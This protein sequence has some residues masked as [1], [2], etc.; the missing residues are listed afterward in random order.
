MIPATTVDVLKEIAMKTHPQWK[1]TFTTVLISTTVLVTL[2]TLTALAQV[3]V[4]RHASPKSG[5][6]NISATTSNTPLFLPVV[7][8]GSG[9]TGASSVAVADVNGDG[10][11]DLVVANICA[12][13]TDCSTGTVAVLLGNG[14]GTFQTAVTYGSGGQGATSVA[15]GDLNGDGKP[16][17]AVVNGSSPKVGVLLGN[18]D[19]TF[20]P[21]QTYPS[22]GFGTSSVAIADVNG[23]GKLD[24]LIVNLEEEGVAGVLL[25]NGDGTFEPVRTISLQRYY[26]RSI[27]VADVNGDG[28]P[29]LV[30]SFFDSCPILSGCVTGGVGVLLGNGD[31]TFQ[32]VQIYN[33]E[34]YGASAVAVADLNGN[35]RADVVVGGSCLTFS[36][37]LNGDL[38]VLLGNGDHTFQPAVGYGSG[39]YNV[40]SVAVADVNGDGKPDLLVANECPFSDCF[41]EAVVGVL[42]GNGDGTFQKAVTF[43][44]GGYLAYGVAVGDVNGDGR[45]DVV[46]ANLCSD[47]FSCNSEDGTVGGLGSVGVLLNN[48]QGKSTTSTSL[49]SSL[50]PSTYGQKITWTATVTSSGSVTPTGKVKFTWNGYTIGAATLN[51][52]GVA[53]LTK[54]NLN[55]DAYPLTAVYAGDAANL[56]STSAVLNQVV[57]ETT[58]TATLTSSPNPSTQGQAVTFTVKISSPTVTPTGP[59]TFT[60]G[61]TVLGTAQLSGGKATLTTSALFV[62]STKVT[63]TYYGD[64]NIAKSSASVTQTVQ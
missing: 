2:S 43:S 23:D 55:A 30:V 29:D 41:N 26:P 47:P 14:D 59:V 17:L 24:L 27:A 57:F 39:A 28:K 5:T 51:S 16:D 45:P 48:A 33:S 15:V 52:S 9:G 31:G 8:Y 36:A 64:S 42:Q 54:S 20:Q 10:K 18:G 21:V 63:V 56:G 58:S 19:G 32:P 13:S 3:K 49:T 60:A 11:P 35:G 46:V 53:T 44:S 12:S 50:N 37:C 25:G 40:L 4:T 1:K 34:I 62:G 6:A 61:K 22:G 7:T 38:G